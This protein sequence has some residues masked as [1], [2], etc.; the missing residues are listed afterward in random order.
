MSKKND[1]FP[2]PMT[3][4]EFYDRA[5]KRHLYKV[6]KKLDGQLSYAVIG[7]RYYSDTLYDCGYNIL[8]LVKDGFLLCVDEPF[9]WQKALVGKNSHTVYSW[10][11]ECQ[12]FGINLPLNNVCGN[13]GYTK[14]LTYYDAQTINDNMQLT[15]EQESQVSDTK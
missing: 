8:Q 4:E 15:P 5:S 6:L 13:C 12:S 1:L 3:K 14:C 9:E 7:D 11:S 10:C 2:T